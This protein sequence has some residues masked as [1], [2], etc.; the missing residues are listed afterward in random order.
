[1]A[2]NLRSSNGSQ[3]ALRLTSKVFQTKDMATVF[4]RYLSFE[5]RLE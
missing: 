4:K 3:H 5:I 1:M 2:N